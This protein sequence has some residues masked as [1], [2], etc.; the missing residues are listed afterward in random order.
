[1]GRVELGMGKLQGV[2]R[3]TLFATHF[4]LHVV[5]GGDKFL[6]PFPFVHHTHVCFP[7]KTNDAT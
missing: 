6:T 5:G 3:L 7:R 2:E 4:F 1:V